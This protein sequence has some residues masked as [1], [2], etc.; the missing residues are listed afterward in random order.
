MECGDLSP[1]SEFG[2]DEGAGWVKRS[3]RDAPKAASQRHACVVRV[4][5]GP[6]KTV[7]AHCD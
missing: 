6:S 3:T 1:L 4:I 2:G 5:Y 7:S